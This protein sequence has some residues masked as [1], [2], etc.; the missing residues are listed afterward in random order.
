MAYR[1]LFLTR[2]HEIDKFLHHSKVKVTDFSR[3]PEKMETNE[4]LAGSIKMSE[5]ER[6]S[7]RGRERSELVKF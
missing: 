7:E 2:M 4:F 3:K 1:K 6:E 5:I